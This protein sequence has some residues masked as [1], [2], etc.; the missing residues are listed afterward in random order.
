MTWREEADGDQAAGALDS[1]LPLGGGAAWSIADGDSCLICGRPGRRNGPGHPCVAV[2]RKLEMIDLTEP[3]SSAASIAFRFGALWWLQFGG[4][5]RLDSQQRFRIP[6][7][8]FELFSAQTLRRT[9]GGIVHDEGDFALS[10]C[11]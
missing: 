6:Q 3:A 11:L 1:E 8:R 9:G 5:A 4:G 10:F 2:G 7:D